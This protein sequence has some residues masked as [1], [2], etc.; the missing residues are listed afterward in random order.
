MLNLELGVYDSDRNVYHDFRY[1]VGPRLMVP[2]RRISIAQLR[3]GK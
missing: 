3:K 1:C 2:E